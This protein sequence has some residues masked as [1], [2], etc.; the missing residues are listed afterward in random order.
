MDKKSSVGA[1]A[2]GAITRLNFALDRDVKEVPL[3][4]DSAVHC[5]HSGLRDGMRLAIKFIQAELELV[6]AKG[7]GDAAMA[8]GYPG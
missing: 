4:G 7:L 3:G 5:Y 6:D 1:F 8:S 2:E